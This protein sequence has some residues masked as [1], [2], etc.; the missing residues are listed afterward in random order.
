[1]LIY[2]MGW[3]HLQG[4]VPAVLPHPLLGPLRAPPQV[5]TRGLCAGSRLRPRALPPGGPT[6]ASA[7]P[8]TNHLLSSRCTPALQAAGVGRE[9]E[10]YREPSCSVA[11]HW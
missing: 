9:H 10:Q 6:R 2:Q 8:F 4:I 7:S 11:F 5:A 1:M 3:P